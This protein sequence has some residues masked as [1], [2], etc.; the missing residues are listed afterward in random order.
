MIF[1]PAISQQQVDACVDA[2]QLFRIGYSWGGAVSLVV[3][4]EMN[5]LRDRHSYQGNLVRFYIGLE[6]PQDLIDDLSQAL[7]QIK[8]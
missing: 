3:P 6:D 5:Q 4:Y 2:M 1:Q 7:E 8:E